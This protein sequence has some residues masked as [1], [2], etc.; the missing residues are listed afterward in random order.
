MSAHVD[1]GILHVVK[2]NLPPVTGLFHFL[3]QVTIIVDGVP[4]QVDNLIGHDIAVLILDRLT[5]DVQA[6]HG[7]SY[8]K[9][10][11]VHASLFAQPA[12]D[13]RLLHDF[14]TPLGFD[15]GGFLVHQMLIPGVGARFPLPFFRRISPGSGRVS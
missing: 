10:V 8:E 4:I 11:R 13:L 7:C 15:R 5:V 14:A 3:N 12:Q 2:L 6:R 9:D 1:Q